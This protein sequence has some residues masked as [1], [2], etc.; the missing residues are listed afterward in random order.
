MVLFILFSIRRTLIYHL[1]ERMIH[2][3]LFQ[4]VDDIMPTSTAVPLSPTQIVPARV[5][6]LRQR[7]AADCAAPSFKA[8]IAMLF[9]KRSNTLTS[10]FQSTTPL[11]PL[12]MHDQSPSWFILRS[13]ATAD[14]QYETLVPTVVFTVLALLMVVLRWCSR[15]SC[16]SATVKSEDYVVTAAMV[17]TRKRFLNIANRRRYSPSASQP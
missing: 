8:T 9:C 13:K 1:F 12:Q 14:I 10:D 6:M 2:K 11:F 16:R 3:R 5:C 7:N 15:I 4:W 17:S